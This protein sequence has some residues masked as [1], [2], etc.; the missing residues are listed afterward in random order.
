MKLIVCSN[1]AP[2]WQNGVGLLPRSP[3]G[4]VPL[5]VTLLEEFGG[6]WICTAP[7]GVPDRDGEPVRLPGEVTLHQV[8]LPE[9]VLEQHYLTIGVRLMLWLFHYLLDTSREPAF[10]SEFARAWAGYEAV[11]RAYAGRLAG[12]AANS[13][14][15][16]ILINDYH[17]F[18]LPELLSGPVERRGR[19]AFFHGLPWCEPDYYGILPAAIRDRILV[20]LLCCDV[21]GFHDSRW[22]AAFL[23]CCARFLPGCRVS[24]REVAYQGH[25]TRIAVAPFPLDIDA[26]RRMD[27]ESSTDRWRERMAVLGAGRRVVARADRLDLWKN[28]PRG[29]AA[30]RAL[31]D[32]EPDLSGQWWFCAVATP[33][34]RTTER[35]REHQRLCEAMVADIND[36]F[37]TPDRPAV[38]LVYPDAASSRNCVTAALSGAE[39][40]LVNPTI[41]GMNLVAK[42]ALFLAERAPLLLSVN[43]GAYEHLA[44]H[45]MPVQPYDVTATATALRE[46]MGG[47]GSAPCGFPGGRAE[48]RHLLAGQGAAGWLAQLADSDP[49]QSQ[50]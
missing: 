27:T 19:L 17:L 26:L 20:S 39:V 14:D 9:P 5:L 49:R 22:A 45:V 15:E 23:S 16:L 35:S 50:R 46:A 12:V 33:P 25:E 38:S 32:R 13:V 30:Y 10:D 28:Q 3:G 34:S 31:L 8:R 11:N 40:T 21:V 42:E 1:S 41:D 4:L 24:E 36:R 44:G 18:L 37:A 48:L 2:R 6:D 7:A 43:A 47:T 29:F